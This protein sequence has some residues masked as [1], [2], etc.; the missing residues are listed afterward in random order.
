MDDLNLGT[1][2][3]PGEKD[4]PDPSL[5]GPIRNIVAA[6]HKWGG[7][8]TKP[9]FNKIKRV[10]LAKH[11][12]VIAKAFG[13]SADKAAAWIKDNWA[14]AHGI[15]YKGKTG[16]GPTYWRK[17]HTMAHASMLCSYWQPAP[18]EVF[19]SGDDEAELYCAGDAPV[20]RDGLIWKTV[21]REGTWKRNPIAGAKGPLVINEEF[22]DDL[23]AAFADN[24]WEF[25]T[26]PLTHADRVDENT[27]YVRA[28]EKYTG[29][30]GKARLRCGFE[31]TEPEVKAKVMRGSIA[32][33]SVGVGFNLERTEDGKKYPRVLKHVA[34]TNAPWINGLPTF[35]KEKLA[36]G[37]MDVSEVS[38][39]YAA[40]DEEFDLDGIDL[41]VLLELPDLSDWPVPS[42]REAFMDKVHV[43]LD[44]TFGASDD[45]EV[46]TPPDGVE[47]PPDKVTKPEEGVK[48]T[49]ITGLPNT[50]DGDEEEWVV[51]SVKIIAPT[52]EELKL[53]EGAVT[54]A[55]CDLAKG[56][57]FVSHNGH[58]Y[59]HM[60]HHPVKK[61]HVAAVNTQT[62]K[63][64]AFPSGM[65]VRKVTSPHGHTPSPV[66]PVYFGKGGDHMAE[67][68]QTKELML[69]QDD[70]ERLVSERVEA[71][72]NAARES[73]KAEAD[74]EREALEMELSR[75]RRAVHE[76]KVKERVA[77]MT[78]AGHAPSLVKKAREILLADDR[79]TDVLNLS[80][81]DGEVK[82]SVTDVVLELMAAV[83]ATELTKEQPKVGNFSQE[84]EEE[85]STKKADADYDSLFGTKKAVT[86]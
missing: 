66:I 28:L 25:V 73:A 62:G 24:A 26:I 58:A 14:A 3:A 43:L 30:D 5:G 83:P 1:P 10:L 18:D 27:G 22:M 8:G 71:G 70:L 52:E 65:V 82:L 20:E 45:D 31:F 77:E 59:T 36:A 42:K 32:N 85:D 50:K 48:S 68:K 11:P 19:L 16:S 44:E 67:E 49:S 2:K 55:L 37:K 78:A 64:S 60:G 38:V 40:E 76:M 33:V 75:N 39:A 54:C 72:L 34:L 86:T 47:I 57:V 84:P 21:L 35:D 12:E 53:A 4:A 51:A 15:S 63:M 80:R 79:H 9:E 29:E 41:S 61:N 69:T 23:I 74:R 81:E 13:G 17:G 7:N 6:A 56:D 46:E